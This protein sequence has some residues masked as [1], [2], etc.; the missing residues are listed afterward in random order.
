MSVLVLGASGQLA[1]HLRE[2]MPNAAY[3]GEEK[4]D[5]RQPANVR[6]AIEAH[7][8]PAIVN[9][10]A[11]TDV[12]K[13]ESERDAAWAVNAEAP[14]M[15]ARAAAALAVPLIHISSDYVFGGTKTAST[16]FRIPAIRSACTAR[17]SSGAS[18][19]CDRCLR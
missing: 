18:S 11:Y 6:A 4:L 10:A 15:I 8:P 9:A 7:R 17:A 2:L 1:T 14:A 16:R 12:D 5:L 19:P 13:A 3:W